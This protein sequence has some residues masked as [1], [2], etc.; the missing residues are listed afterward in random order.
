MKISKRIIN[1]KDQLFACEPSVCPE[2]AL[3]ITEAY[4]KSEAEPLVLKRAIALNHILEN[5]T[6]YIREGELIVGNQ[7]SKFGAIPVFPETQAVWVSEQL[8]NFQKREKFRYIVTAETKKALRNILSYWR[9]KTVQEKVPKML[10]ETTR[11][12]LEIKNPV[13]SADYHLRYGIGHVLPNYSKI[14]K[15][16]LIHIKEE[17][18]KS[19]K[20]L[21]LSKAESMRKLHFFNAVQ[22]I[23][24][25][26]I[27]FAKRYSDLALELAQKEKG[28][29]RKKELE[30][31]SKIC[32]RVPAYPATDLH[33][34]LQSFWFLHLII[35][36]ESDG[37]AFSPGRFDQYI[38]PYYS[39]GIDDNKLTKEFAQ[40]LVDSLWIKF[41]EVQY[42][43][44]VQPKA[45]Y[46]SGFSMSQNII[47][48]GQTRDGE[49]ATNDLSYI[50]L[51]ADKHIRFPQP[52][53]SIRMHKSTP[54]DFLEKS[55][56][57]IKLG[58]GKP[59]I[60]ND[61][62][63]IPSLVKDGVS[64]EDARDYGIVGCVEPAPSK[65]CFG[66][67]NPAMFNLA[68]CLELALNDG[69]DMLSGER[70]SQ[71]RAK[72]NTY[73]DIWKSFKEQVEFFV[74]HMIIILNTIDIAHK[75]NLPLPY[76]S[77]LMD[78]C[79][80]KGKDI[81]EGGAKYNYMGPQG[82][83]LADVA[84][85]LSVLKKIVFE[86]KL[87]NFSELQNI[88]RNNFKDNERVR[89]LLINRAPKYGNDNVYVD[90]IARDVGKLYCQ[91]VSKYFNPRGGIYRPG[92]YSVAAHV[93]LGQAVGALP[94]GK[95]AREGLTDGI[96]PVHGCDRK[97][98]TAIIKSASMVEHILAS[99]GT[100]LNP[101]IHTTC[102]RTQEDVC[103]FISLL[104]T[105][106]NL[107]DMHIQFNV[108]SNK[109]LRKA[110]K[111]P[112]KYR[113]LLIRISGWSAF[114]VEL[115]EGLQ[116]DII[117]RTEHLLL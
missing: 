20:L 9:E 75:E 27:N 2:R 80:E 66:W 92:L 39:K 76:L 3:L 53:L 38:Y 114:F 44:N 64:L 11:K 82:V 96:S 105:F 15:Y 112:E 68:K 60:F 12:F 58:G 43:A 67:T 94:N 98:I 109:L 62:I 63:I 25:G 24:D 86:Q 107:K 99:N 22:I 108:V 23:C 52:A 103:K 65:N 50:C 55:I 74:P 10:P 106:V 17:V 34:A 35:E 31:I 69:K 48:G 57:L 100:N 104:R 30:K 36:I 19:I 71:I 37:R 32:K 13:I 21:D 45:K 72:I 79:L 73:E 14:L 117:S 116:E 78:N 8:D 83:G 95:R 93:P 5:M 97:G 26:V 16:G 81:T 47:L 84:D 59:A 90:K 85:S 91:T 87:I 56:E 4:Q 46:C 89:Q 88:L 49:D 110:Q 33:E 6:I 77:I 41:N 42:L 51:T 61:E 102:L 115:D 111:N 101:K 1:L 29:K 7:A 18:V 40:E 70:V 28:K 54:S 113:G